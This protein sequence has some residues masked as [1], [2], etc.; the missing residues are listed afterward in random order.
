[1]TKYRGVIITHGSDELAAVTALLA[2][3]VR[4]HIAFTHLETAQELNL[5]QAHDFILS[6]DLD[7][8][9]EAVLRYEDQG[10]AQPLYIHVVYADKINLNEPY[11]DFHR[12]GAV[13]APIRQ[14]SLDRQDTTLQ[15]DLFERVLKILNAQA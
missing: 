15:L 3:R 9:R 11:A 8:L 4:Q 5:N 10:K 1:M 6:D 2:V 13:V 7:M 14:A 12:R